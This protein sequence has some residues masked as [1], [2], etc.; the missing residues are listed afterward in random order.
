MEKKPKVRNKSKFAF[1]CALVGF[2]L[3]ISSCASGTRTTTRK[4][5]GYSEAPRTEQVQPNTPAQTVAHEQSSAPAQ[6]S[7]S[8]ALG[9]PVSTEL[10]SAFGRYHQRFPAVTRES[11]LTA[12][13]G[14]QIPDYCLFRDDPAKA[15]ADY[16]DYENDHGRK[17]TALDAYQA[18]LLTEG[19]NDM[20]V[21]IR[22]WGGLAQLAIEGKDNYNAQVYLTKILDKDPN[23]KWAKQRLSGILK[24]RYE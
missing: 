13:Q 15:C 10:E 11:F 7:S 16:G 23:N 18:G 5:S 8:Q 3:V 4:R 6:V 9:E 17:K 1:G 21:N 19:Y 22:L 24:Q 20:R 14:R 12:A 2:A